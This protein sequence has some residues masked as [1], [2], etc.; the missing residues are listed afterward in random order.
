VASEFQYNGSE[1][2]ALEMELVGCKYGIHINMVRVYF[3]FGNIWRKSNRIGIY[4]AIIRGKLLYV[5]YG[6]NIWKYV[7]LDC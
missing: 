7:V 2:W 5:L 1:E 6:G 3:D 4:R